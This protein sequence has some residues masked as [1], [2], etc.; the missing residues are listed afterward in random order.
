MPVAKYYERLATFQARGSQGRI[1]IGSMQHSLKFG[2]TK[3]SHKVLRDIH[4]RCS[5][6]NVATHI[7]I[8]A[9]GSPADLE[10]QE[11]TQIHRGLHQSRPGT[12]HLQDVKAILKT[13]RNMHTSD[14]R[15]SK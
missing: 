4:K 3:A 15:R 8:M 1:T 2:S 7:T 5:A 6:S 14:R 9:T 12:Q 13:W 10:L 11:A